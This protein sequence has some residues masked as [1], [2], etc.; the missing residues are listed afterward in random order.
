MDGFY[1]TT[2]NGR[3]FLTKDSGEVTKGIRL[4]IIL[5]KTKTPGYELQR[6][7]YIPKADSSYVSDVNQDSYIRDQDVIDRLGTS[8]R[9]VY[10][11]DKDFHKKNPPQLR[12][13][14]WN[15]DGVLIQAENKMG[16][17]YRGLLYG[18]NSTYA[19]DERM[20][21]KWFSKVT[22]ARKPT[23]MLTIMMCRC[24]CGRNIP[25]ERTLDCHI[26]IL[27]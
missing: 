1:W 13:C 18:K 26:T 27:G 11:K 22:H 12:F 23:C 10:A 8:C 5:Y 3:P 17:Y 21:E 25:T 9:A 14:A 6:F 2:K 15:K 16:D 24:R 7:V 19:P 20:F 4:N